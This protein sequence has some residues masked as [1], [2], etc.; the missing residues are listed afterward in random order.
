[1]TESSVDLRALSRGSEIESLGTAGVD[2]PLPARKWGLRVLLP[3]VILVAL[4]SLLAM[5]SAD[6]LWPGT[7]VR[8]HPVI[9]KS[10]GESGALAAGSVVVQAPGWVEPDPFPTYVAALADGVVQEV[11]VLEGER[12][13][14]GQLVAR[15]V[16]DD[17]RIALHHAEAV[18]NEKKA[19]L[20]AA[21]AR[22]REAQRNWDHPIE[23]ERVLHTAEARLAEA[24]AKLARWPAEL[25]REQAHAVYLK[26]ELE[27]IRPLAER[28]QA[29][30]IEAIQ[31]EQAYEVQQA[32]VDSVQQE[33]PILTA[34]RDELT[35]E[36]EAAR[37]A[38]TLRIVDERALAEAK[39]LAARGEAELA[40]ADAA[41]ADAE[42]RVERME[43]HTPV[44]GRVMKRLVGTGSKVIEM[45]DSPHS[46]H[47]MHIYDPN[48][49]QVRV[50]I[51][52]VEAAKV[53]VD[54]EAEVIVDVLPERVFQGRV[55]RVVHEADVQ[56]NTLQVKVAIENPS[57]EI[58]PE[59]L[60]RARFLARPE[61]S[62]GEEVSERLFVPR[63]SVAERDGQK[64]VWLADLAERRAR[65]ALVTLEESS[66]D[67]WVQVTSGLRPGD[68]VIV[69]APPGLG[70]GQ[71]ITIVED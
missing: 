69:N 63:R 6:V 37:E 35:A 39:A 52:L 40:A 27:R 34:K 55:S 30:E 66:A 11:L 3:G 12:V 56:K 18:L 36:V 42:L 61:V 4:A 8:V 33:K 31:A 26:A 38:L 45:M 62:S 58:K 60:A 23:L 47:V 68:R 5:T 70:D 65:F 15:L 22:L 59:M 9:V 57:S 51:P 16:A 7:A 1:V 10:G 19:A 48:H 24:E 44:G 41:F 64:F 21:Q 32:V 13:E 25:K 17:A 71:R 20:V 54:Q 53:G 50:D 46:A 14:A 49:L 43:I 2:I 67:E 28:G 29:S